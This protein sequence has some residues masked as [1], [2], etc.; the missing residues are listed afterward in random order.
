MHFLYDDP[1]ALDFTLRYNPV[2]WTTENE[3]TAVNRDAAK[4][5]PWL[6]IKFVPE[7][8]STPAP[9]SLTT[10]PSF[11][12]QPLNWTVAPS[13]CTKRASQYEMQL[14]STNPGSHRFTVGRGKK[15][16]KESCRGRKSEPIACRDLWLCYDCSCAWKVFQENDHFTTSC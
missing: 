2:Y 9:G 8:R 5:T 4:F 16:S 1:D 12:F 14:E 3:A 15:I 6:S 7:M 11:L 10:R 13:S